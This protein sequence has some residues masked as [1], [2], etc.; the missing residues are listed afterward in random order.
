M[1]KTKINEMKQDLKLL[2][3]EEII[4]LTGW[5]ENTVRKIMTEDKDFPTIKIGKKNQVSFD[6]LK[7][8][9]SSRR[10]LRGE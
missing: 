7:E 5:G 8:Y 4:A 3:I 9:L 2:D 10:I 1:E 6:G